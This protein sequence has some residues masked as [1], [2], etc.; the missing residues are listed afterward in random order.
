[1]VNYSNIRCTSPSIA[2]FFAR[3]GELLGSPNGHCLWVGDFVLGDS[4]LELVLVN[5]YPL[6]HQSLD[7]FGTV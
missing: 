5:L 2:F 7:W 4:S 1:M 6:L 3:L